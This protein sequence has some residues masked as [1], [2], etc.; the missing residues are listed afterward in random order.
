MPQLL[1]QRRLRLPAVAPEANLRAVR[2]HRVVVDIELENADGLHAS[3]DCRVL[4]FESRG[5]CSFTFFETTDGLLVGIDL[6]EA[7]KIEWSPAGADVSVATPR[8]RDRL[9]LRF[10]DRKAIQRS[11]LTTR[12]I[13]RLFGDTERG[14]PSIRRIAD[15]CRRHHN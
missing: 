4:W 5:E 1:D 2:D 8:A 7:S 9:A 6:A 3:F 15:V 13:D 11:Q 14:R 12:D 10:R